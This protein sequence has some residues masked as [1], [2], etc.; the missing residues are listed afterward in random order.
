MR[1]SGRNSRQR[2]DRR[3]RPNDGGQR[4]RERKHYGRRNGNDDT[5][6]VNR[7]RGSG[8][9]GGRSD[10]NSGSSRGKG[11]PNSTEI[12]V[13]QKAQ[14]EAEVVVEPTSVNHA[15]IIHAAKQCVAISESC[16]QR[17]IYFYHGLV[18]MSGDNPTVSPTS[19]E[20]KEKINSVSLDH[21]S[22]IIFSAWERRG[23][24]FFYI[25]APLGE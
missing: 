9:R 22:V 1:R 14:V 11:K 3:G 21:A 4:N 15:I 17:L 10:E 16:E 8:G 23:K 5:R 12:I 6:G 2:K 25:G 20:W 24:L 7:N 18:I 19:D 13:H